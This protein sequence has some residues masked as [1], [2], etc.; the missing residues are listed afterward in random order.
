MANQVG[1]DH[2]LVRFDGRLLELAD[3]P[4]PTLLTH[5]SILPKANAASAS[6]FT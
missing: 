5:T 4:T 6:A 1:A 3:R 2:L